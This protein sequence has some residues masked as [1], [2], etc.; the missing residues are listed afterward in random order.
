MPHKAEII[1]L[2]ERGGIA[3]V[4]SVV[5]ADL[6]AIAYL[7]FIPIERNSDGSKSPSGFKLGKIKEELKNIGISVEYVLTDGA[8]PDLESGL[9]AALLMSHGD[10]IR[11]VFFQANGRSGDVWID[12]KRTLEPLVRDQI[13]ERAQGYLKNFEFIVGNVVLTAEDNLP[14]VTVCLKAIRKSAP[15]EVNDLISILRDSNFNIPSYDWM[16][17][18]LDL[19]RK[20]GLVV[21]RGDGRYV[22]SLTGLR[23]LGTGR[24][25]SSPDVARLLALVRRHEI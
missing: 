14:T 6:E 23:A 24:G 21:R 16:R 17:R 19:L 8:A 10:Y 9:R 4:S 20:K 25:R 18:R 7:V 1:S 12:P 2:L 3:N 22:L 5:E 13:R 15:V 11:N